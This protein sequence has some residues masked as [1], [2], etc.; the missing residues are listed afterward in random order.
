MYRALWSWLIC[1]AVTVAVSLMTKP[2]P[3]KQLE[4]LV[5]GCTRD[6]HRKRHVPWVQRPAFWAIVIAVVFVVLNIVFW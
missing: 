6:S 1:V 2:L 3:E 4:G 5:Y